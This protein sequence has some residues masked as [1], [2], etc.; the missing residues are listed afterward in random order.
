[1]CLH[2]SVLSVYRR[3]YLIKST[4]QCLDQ[5]YELCMVSSSRK[6]IF[7][8]IYIF[9]KLAFL[10]IQ[11]T[12][13]I[14]HSCLIPLVTILHQIFNFGNRSQHPPSVS[15]TFI[16]RDLPNF[17]YSLYIYYIATLHVARLW[18]VF[19]QRLQKC[20]LLGVFIC[21]MQFVGQEKIKLE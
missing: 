1:M 7:I 18:P 15:N 19:L 10:F 2:C 6:H 17:S 16:I 3:Q 20:L 11:H 4:L 13:A 12:R 21:Q 8:V 14:L 5:V 9:P